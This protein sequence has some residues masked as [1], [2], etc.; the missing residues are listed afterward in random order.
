MYVLGIDIGGTKCAVISAEWDG[1]HVTLLKKEACS[2]DHTVSGEKMLAR[3]F[4]M[5]DG[6]LEKRPDA[7]GISCGG[8][9]D[10]TRG[11][12][13]SPPNL[14]T[15]DNVEAVRLA[16]E[17][18]GAPARLENDANACA[19]AEWKFGAGR[20][21]NNL[22]FLTFGTGLGAGL[23][24]NGALYVGTNGN[25]GEAGHVR[26]EGAGPVGYGKPGSFEGFCSGGGIA[27]L[28]YEMAQEA[29]KRGIRPLF[30]EDGM[31][32]ENVNARSIAEAALAGDATA[33]EVYRISGKYLGKGLSILIDILNPERIIIG[34]IFA[35][36]R[37][38]LWKTAEDEIKKEALAESVKCC[39]VVAAEL[40]ESIG[41]YAAVATAL[42]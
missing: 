35:R 11:V 12:I 42:L 16:E 14:P 25:A 36:S 41:D 3:L 9:L 34:S 19:V 5:A 1:E 22:V 39:R 18:F 10:S 6:I 27:K 7:V 17:H 28:G 8:P 15:W 40:G 38:L 21:C 32:K 24:L 26:L 2:T 33:R 29:T 31:K 30:F 23:I 4:E 20:G 13:M 37:D